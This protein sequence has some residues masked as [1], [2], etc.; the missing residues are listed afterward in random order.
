MLSG[1]LRSGAVA[2]ALLVGAGL[3]FAYGHGPPPVPMP[4]GSLLPEPTRDELTA[5]R[6]VGVHPDAKRVEARSSAPEVMVPGALGII[7]PFEAADVAALVTGT[8]HA[9]PVRIGDRVRAGDLLASLDAKVPTAALDAAGAALRAEQ[10]RFE[11]ALAESRGAVAREQRATA[12][13]GEGL[14]TRADQE[15]AQ[16]DREVAELRASA[17]EAS[18]AQH[19]ASL[20]R[21]KAEL[22]LYEVRAPFAGSVVARYVDPGAA[23]TASPPRPI[24]RLISSERLF[25]RF[26]ASREVALGMLVLVRSEA[27][28]SAREVVAEVERIAPQIQPG[29]DL[30]LAE[31]R[32]RDAG[33]FLSGE[34]V[35][36]RSGPGASGE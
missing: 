34:V 7:L 30:V 24:V 31:A 22:R 3:L 28:P 10:V 12:L 1:R 21:T 25:V 15:T 16:R 29:T 26:A 33:E 4:D 9:L 8:V 27:G 19:R 32:L 20:E 35:R 36:V 2:G 18:L 23:V 5:E 6:A 17:L 14:T 13:E 11:I